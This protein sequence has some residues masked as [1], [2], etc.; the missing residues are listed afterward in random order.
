MMRIAPDRITTIDSHQVFV[1]G[2]NE[3][4]RHGKGAARTA[5]KWGAMYGQA[6]GLQG[7]TYAIPTVNSSISKSLS[8]ERIKTYVDRFIEFAIHRPDLQFLVTEIGCGL[9]GFKVKTIAPLFQRALTVDNIYLPIR[10]L[11]KLK[12]D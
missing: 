12:N 2:S 3:A 7:N 1:F 6:E 5:M 4:G 11:H 8:V 9:A 10:F